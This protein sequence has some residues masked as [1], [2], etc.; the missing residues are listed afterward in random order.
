MPFKSSGSPFGETI[1][2]PRVATNLFWPLATAGTRHSR[3]MPHKH[4]WFLTRRII[5]EPPLGVSKLRNSSIAYSVPEGPM[6]IDAG[7][8]RTLQ[9]RRSEILDLG[10]FRSA[11][12]KSLLSQHEL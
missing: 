4:A 12:A 2:F 1:S 9:L 7:A 11:G 6:F 3:I 8:Q 10:T 5:C